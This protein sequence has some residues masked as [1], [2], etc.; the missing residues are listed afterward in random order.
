[1]DLDEERR[2]FYAKARGGDENDVDLVSGQLPPNI[3]TTALSKAS[4]RSVE[5]FSC[6]KSE[7]ERKRLSY[8]GWIK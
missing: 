1:M 2:G 6:K 3:S 8:C 5:L 4:A 7:I